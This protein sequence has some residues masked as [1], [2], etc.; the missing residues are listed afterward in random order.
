MSNTSP[1]FQVFELGELNALLRAIVAARFRPVA[2]DP[3]MWAGPVAHVLSE[4]L[5]DAYMN[6]FGAKYGQSAAE[7]WFK[8]LPENELLSIVKGNLKSN[9]KEPWWR[10]MSTQEKELFVRGCVQP[11]MV[12]AEFIRELVRDAET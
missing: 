3:E 4:R 7:L 5:R 12:S 10:S 9:A 1:L 8:S 11:F 6:A 2:D